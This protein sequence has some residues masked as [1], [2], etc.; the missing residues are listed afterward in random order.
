MFTVE[1]KGYR[2]LIQDLQ[3]C[4]HRFC[5]EPTDGFL[6]MFFLDEFELSYCRGLQDLATECN[7][8]LS[9]DCA[10]NPGFHAG[11]G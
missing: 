2:S 1:Q 11:E 10:G 3:E 6:E 7:K 8:A 9:S 4:R 5:G